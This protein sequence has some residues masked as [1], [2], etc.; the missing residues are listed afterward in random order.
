MLTGLMRALQLEALDPQLVMDFGGPPPARQPVP[1][2][3]PAEL[4]EHFKPQIMQ[5]LGFEGDEDTWQEVTEGQAD[6]AIAMRDR[7][8]QMKSRDIWV[9][10]S[11]PSPDRS[12]APSSGPAYRVGEV[13]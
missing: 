4:L 9:R 11:W 8:D 13:L 12:H 5:T 3:D 7:D 2:M 6:M 1:K 10:P